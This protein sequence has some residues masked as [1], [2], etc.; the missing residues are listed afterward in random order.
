MSRQEQP[1]REAEHRLGA[2]E[3]VGVQRLVER[4]VCKRPVEG[5]Q[6]VQVRRSAPEV[7]EDDQRRL[8]ADLTDPPAEKQRVECGVE[9]VQKARHRQNQGPRPVDRVDEEVV[10]P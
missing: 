6:V 2:E 8:D 3:A 10:F 4:W 9:R 1:G 5:E 7:P